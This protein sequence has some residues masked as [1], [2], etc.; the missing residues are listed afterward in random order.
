MNTFTYQGPVID[1]LIEIYIFKKCSVYHCFSFIL[2]M[3]VKLPVCFEC[4]DCSALFNKRDVLKQHA[5]KEHKLAEKVMLKSPSGRAETKWIRIAEYSVKSY[6]DTITFNLLNDPVEE[7]TLTF[8]RNN[9]NA[10]QQEDMPDSS[11][12]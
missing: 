5:L 1:W 11:T 9:T 8:L 12:C 2:N 10:N 7:L 6:A 3:S 4:P